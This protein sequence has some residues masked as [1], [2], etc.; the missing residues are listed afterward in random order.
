MEKYPKIDAEKA[1]D[2]V[3]GF[4][5]AKKFDLVDWGYHN[6]EAYPD[7]TDESM[8]ELKRFAEMWSEF[9]DYADTVTEDDG[10]GFP[11]DIAERY[12]AEVGRVEKAVNDDD[13]FWAEIREEIIPLYKAPTDVKDSKVL[14]IFEE[15]WERLRQE[16]FFDEDGNEIVNSASLID[17]M[18]IAIEEGDLTKRLMKAFNRLGEE[19][20][21]GRQV[22]VADLD[23]TRLLCKNLADREML[24]NWQERWK[25][26]EMFYDPIP[27]GVKT[28]KILRDPETNE[29]VRRESVSERVMPAGFVIKVL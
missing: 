18:R 5:R 27:M 8:P 26:V 13:A 6:I 1:A 9:F 24:R 11:E 28:D 12:E 23:A 4:L 22:G 2:E 14:D 20:D 29:E 15:N 16:V 19:M 3:K 25:T 7:P 17:D 10:T 21:D